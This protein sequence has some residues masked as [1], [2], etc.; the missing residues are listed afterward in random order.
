MKRLVND[1][2]ISFLI[3]L[4]LSFL[5]KGLDS[6]VRKMS[7]HYCQDIMTTSTLFCLVEMFSVNSEFE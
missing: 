6:G 7:W 2:C 4:T 1:G 3:L 5:T